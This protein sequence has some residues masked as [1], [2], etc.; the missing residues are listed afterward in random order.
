MNNQLNLFN[1]HQLIKLSCSKVKTFDGCKAQYRYNYIEK[2][3][4]KDWEHHALGQF[5][6]KILEDFHQE[7]I[8]KSQEP[9]AKTMA[10]VYKAAYQ[11]FKNKLSIESKKEARNII[12]AYLKR[13]SL[14]RKEV[15]N[16]ISVEKK[17]ELKLADN[18]ILTGMIDK[19]QIDDD[20]VVHVCDYKTIKNKKY[21]KDDFLQL[22]TY[23]YVLMMED[24]SI[25]N[26]RTSY[27][28]LRHNFQYFTKEYTRKDIINI[29]DIYI[30]YASD[31]NTE[32]LWRPNPSILC[33]YCDFLDVCMTGKK[34]LN[35]DQKNMIYGK[36]EW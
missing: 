32:E 8:N 4:K 13:I 10:K 33:K 5:V 19:V 20:N 1:N 14:N 30:K 15:D 25:Q 23:A 35:Q 22:Q 7:Y 17:F 9:F 28:L 34:F 27:I 18:V 36:I 11:E 16:V 31:I 6:H 12:G 26:I 3:P 21:L 24:P 2:L 29:G